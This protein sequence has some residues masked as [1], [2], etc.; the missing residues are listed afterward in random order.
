M[1]KLLEIIT[2]IP[3]GLIFNKMERLTS[4]GYRWAPRTFLGQKLSESLW[5]NDPDFL[6]RE[7]GMFLSRHGLMVHYP[8][9][10]LDMDGEQ[11][12][13]L[14]AISNGKKHYKVQLDIDETALL[15]R[16]EEQKP[17]T[18]PV[19]RIWEHA[20]YAV[21]GE[22]YALVT[23]SI[24]ASDA[25]FCA[26]DTILGEDDFVWPVHKLRYVCPATVEPTKLRGGKEG[27]I[28]FRSQKKWEWVIS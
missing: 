24:G 23:S 20:D 11:A 9:Y 6:N 25:V 18:K 22:K 4:A 14:T 5:K 26:F 21:K 8:A 2:M 3:Q 27:L 13:V 10:L 17:E 7:G 16:L 19:H 1:E 15:L 12:A 28:P